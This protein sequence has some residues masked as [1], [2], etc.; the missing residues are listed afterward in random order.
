M[1]GQL[2]RYCWAGQLC[3]GISSG[4]AAANIEDTDTRHD[5]SDT[6]EDNS[7][8]NGDTNGGTNSE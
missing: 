3:P 1:Q 7:D 5:N 6:D 2:P 8:T 4:W